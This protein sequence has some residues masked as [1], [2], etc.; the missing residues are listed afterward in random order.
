MVG[1]FSC[2][3]AKRIYRWYRQVLSGY[4]DKMEGEIGEYDFIHKGQLIKV[5]IC[6]PEHIGSD[7][8][9]DEKNISNTTY[10]VLANNNSGK[11][12]MLIESMQSIH[13][14]KALEHLGDKRFIVK[15]IS[16]DLSKVYDWVCRQSFMN[17][18]QIADKFH[19]LK[20]GFESLQSMRIYLRQAELHRIKELQ[21]IHTTTELRKKKQLKKQFNKQYQPAKF[22]D[23][24]HII[25]DNGESV[26]QLLARSRY[27]LFKFEKDWSKEQKQRAQ[28]LFELH[29]SIQ[30]AYQ[31]ICKFR[32]WY[33]KSNIGLPTKQR[34]AKLNQWYS[35]VKESGIV[36][37]Q[38]FRAL[39]KRHEGLIINYFKQGRTNAM[40]EAINNK[41]QR[42]ISTSHGARDLDFFL[43]RLAIYFS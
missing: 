8:T 15:R 5:P 43:F 30:I 32:V 22:T 6:K 40:A 38:I 33:S 36:S 34:L 28:L 39:V 18:E 20:N 31:L 4:V 10:T 7:M 21:D 12:A 2:V 29:P 25:L 24:Q 19:V 17:A 41:I 9:I 27:L 42:F 35:D 1:Q 23:P 37:M 3:P 13:I 11:I 14:V 26:L 16:R